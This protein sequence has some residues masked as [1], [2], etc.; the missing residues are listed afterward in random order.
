MA[1]DYNEAPINV[2]GGKSR[3]NSE[4][5]DRFGRVDSY[6]EP[7]FGSGAVML[8]CP[9]IPE[10]ETV[11]DISG[12]IVNM[13]RAIKY[14]PVETSNYALN[15]VFE[16]DLTAKHI[17]MLSQKEELVSKLESSPD[18]YDSV[19]AGWFAWACACWIGDGLLSGTGPWR[20][21][22]GRLVKSDQPGPGIFKK[23]PE[24]RS[25]H[26]VNR[27]NMDVHRWFEILS[28]RF[29]NTRVLCGDWTRLKSHV[30]GTKAEIC[31]VFLDPPYESYEGLYSDGSKNIAKDVAEWAFEIGTRKNIR[32]AL[33]GYEGDYV[34]PGDWEVFSWKSLGGYSLLSDDS[35][36]RENRDKERILFSPY[37]NKGKQVSVFDL[38]KRNKEKSHVQG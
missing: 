16:L 25:Q 12:F 22:D 2:F 11:N 17:W 26:G 20:L 18:F 4:T 5:W 29:R 1:K 15:P 31:G 6:V 8:G 10:Q 32:V 21:I 9:Y 19:I 34:V 24:I 3:V 35:E 36:A 33:C 37:C 27:T 23:I 28:K 14:N 38:I 13:Y 30:E 7:F